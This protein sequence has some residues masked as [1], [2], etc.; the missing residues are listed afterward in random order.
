MLINYLKVALRNL[1]Q[2]ASFSV[3]NILGLSLGLACSLLILL[4]VRDEESVDSFNSNKDQLYVMYER[5][6]SP[7][8]KI[9]AD[10]SAPAPLG[11]ELK[12][13]IPEVRY[14]VSTDWGDD[15]T[16]RA[17]DKAL[18]ARGGY[19]GEDFF[20]MFSYPLLQGNSNSALT[21]PEGIVISKTLAVNLFGSTGAAMG[22]TLRRDLDSSW[23]NFVVT[24][25]FDDVPQNSSLKFEFLMS[26]KAYYQEHPAWER[27]DNSGPYT[28]IQL[29]PDA[30]P[31]RVAAKLRRFMDKYRPNEVPGYRTELGMQRFDQM[32]LYS[33]FT[34]GYTSGGR[35]EYVR[36]F[37]LVAV[38]ILV[39]A[40]INFMNL[41]TAR[42][43][44]RAKEIGVRKVVG[45]GKG[46]LVA[47]FLGEA[48]LLATLAMAVA[49]LV[50]WLLLPV[51]NGITEKEIV[52]PAASLLFWLQLIG[53]TIVTGL[54][55][56]SYPALYLSSFRPVAVLK[57][58]LRTGTGAALF[59]RGLVVFQFTLSIFLIIGTIVVT[60]QVKYIQ[61]LD[62]GFNRESL[63]YIPIEGTLNNKYKLFKEQG[64]TLPGIE[65][66]SYMSEKPTFIDNG[67]SSIEW[68]GKPANSRPSIAY[69]GVGY[70]FISTV[71][72]RIIEGRDLSP[73]FATDSLAF[74]LN[75]EA[76]R[77]LGFAR[78]AD[79][80]GLDLQM[81]T[82]KG[83]VVGVVKD[84]HFT[85]LH[86]PIKPL[87]LIAREQN[88]AG[89]IMVR[90]KPGQTRQAIAALQQ[91]CRQLNPAFPFTY[92][93]ADA[94]YQ[95][96][97]SDEGVIS[98]LSNYFAGIAILISC[99]GLLGLAMFT[100]EQRTKEIGI[101]KI[102]GAGTGTLFALLARDFV[103]L[104][105]LAFVIAAPVAGWALQ[106]WLEDYS[107]HTHLSNGVFVIAGLLSFSI[108]LATISYH[109]IRVALANPVKSLRSE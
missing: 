86:D 10:Y 3:L 49:L 103:W 25:V 31:G 28:M 8:N 97:Y 90:T 36:L 65:R 35:I 77:T 16:F 84:F 43:V 50:L 15:F 82:L 47:Q 78:P 12:R 38:F 37:G 57:G 30:D 17:T 64:L 67:T 29:R 55:A 62:L 70:D 107:Y 54:L 74:L 88:A 73:A 53:L 95:K 40:C 33:R 44:R 46:S 24:G 105:A 109:A 76:V 87:V 6:F 27:W 11:A 71:G 68:P 20:K 101:R 21:Q 100:A 104:V 94:E 69:A 106:R 108:A 7:D 59:R 52:L 45:A 48:L 102:L 81:W 80:I 2:N 92:Q 19:A 75:E 56:G 18:K 61:S 14:A 83:K 51:F 60:K 39:I 63:V 42:S 9:S 89:N 91:L 32:Y 99:L 1:R 5:G 96:L 72:A 23:K 58:V 85:S 26:W 4:W 22:K 93:F 79:V 66:I 98:K 13:S 41:T 34:N